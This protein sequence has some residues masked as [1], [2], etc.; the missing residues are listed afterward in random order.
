MEFFFDIFQNLVDQF[1]NPKKRVFVL[2][3]FLSILIAT[4]WLI[5]YKKKSFKDSFNFIFSRKIFFSK[6]AKS[7]YKVFFINHND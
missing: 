3:L 5:F 1:T 2:Y 7:D 6:S 4:G